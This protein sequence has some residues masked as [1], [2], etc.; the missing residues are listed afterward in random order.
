MKLR[1]IMIFPRITNIDIIEKIR[2]QFDPLYKLVNPHITIVFPFDD[3]MSNEELR[4]LLEKHL[5]SIQ[6][7]NIELKGF[8]MQE[9][10]HGN[11]LFLNVIEGAE[12]IKKIHDL[13]YLE[14]FG[15]VKFDPEY[16]PHITVGKLE[17]K[18]MMHEAYNT[19]KDI[20]TKFSTLVDKIAVEMIGKNEESII[21][22]E[23]SL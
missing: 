5:R 2:E 17:S 13:L 8:S 23:K 18:V 22:I 6:P 10:K 9:D 20:D 21:I 14:L 1:T 4:T 7:F 19:V 16:V 11:Y 3:D 12:T 15:E